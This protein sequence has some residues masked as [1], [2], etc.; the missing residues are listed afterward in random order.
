MTTAT[1]EPTGLPEDQIGAAGD[2]ARALVALLAEAGQGTGEVHLRDMSGAD[3][4]IPADAL[5]L[6]AHL[7]AFLANGQSVTVIPDHAELSTQQVADLLN[8]SRPHVVKLI[9]ENRLPARRVGAHRRVRFEDLMK[10]KQ[11][12]EA[13][14][15]EA[16]AELARDAQEMGLGY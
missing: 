1:L 8:V 4:A 12:A 13:R 6:F 11:R 14:R 2:A 5:R 3:I 16:L 7:L 10:Y 15:E 9:E